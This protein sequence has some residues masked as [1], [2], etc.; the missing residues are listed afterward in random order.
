MIE[1][2]LYAKKYLKLPKKLFFFSK[3]LSNN[4]KNEN[5]LQINL[6]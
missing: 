2:A 1:S 5:D 6:L 4:S 3:L